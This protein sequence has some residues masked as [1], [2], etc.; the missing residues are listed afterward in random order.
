MHMK[1]VS[2]LMMHEVPICTY[3]TI[4]EVVIYNPAR[5]LHYEEGITSM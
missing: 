5:T 3:T 4:L 2:N 1:I